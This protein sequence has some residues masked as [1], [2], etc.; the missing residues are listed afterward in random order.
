METFINRAS[1]DAEVVALL[2]RHGIR[3]TRQRVQIGAV[4]FARNQHVT[5]AELQSQL[6]SGG[7]VMARGTIYNTL[8]LFAQKGL[9]RELDLGTRGRVY[10]TN[11][12]PHFHLHHV[13]SGR[14][15]DLDMDQVDVHVPERVLGQSQLVGVDVTVRVSG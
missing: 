8:E 3:P 13:N 9:V 4:L 2:R 11:L 5:A 7:E 12:K 1:N 15:E 6:E 14:I 10:D